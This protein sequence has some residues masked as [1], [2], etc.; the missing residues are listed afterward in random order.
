VLLPER[1]QVGHLEDLQPTLT[2]VLALS[3]EQ[4]PEWAAQGVVAEGLAQLMVLQSVHE[5]RH[6]AAWTLGQ[7]LK[8][9]PE[10][11]PLRRRRRNGLQVSQNLH[12]LLGPSS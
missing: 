12:P 6:R 3:I 7:E 10:R 5:V 11:G 1:H 2:Q 9:P 8:S 4:M